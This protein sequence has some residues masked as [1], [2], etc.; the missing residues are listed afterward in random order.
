[1]AQLVIIWADYGKHNINALPSPYRG[2]PGTGT[3]TAVQENVF[4][5]GVMSAASG[6]A[7]KGT[8]NKK[9]ILVKALLYYCTTMLYS[10]V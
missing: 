10:T 3:V 7:G 6:R 8:Q 4:Y 1:L 2:L 9:K 5:P